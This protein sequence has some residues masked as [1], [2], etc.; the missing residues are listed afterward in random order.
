MVTHIVFR[1]SVVAMNIRSPVLL[2]VLS[3][4]KRVSHRATSCR[5]VKVFYIFS[6]LVGYRKKVAAPTNEGKFKKCLQDTR[7]FLRI[8]DER[9]QLCRVKTLRDSGEIMEPY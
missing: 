6:A 8:R 3:R 5:S 4:Y 2:H 1:V 7:S 9:F